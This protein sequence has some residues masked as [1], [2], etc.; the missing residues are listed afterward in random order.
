[1]L[2]ET[3][4]KGHNDVL[5][6]LSALLAFRL[7][8]RGGLVAGVAGGLV[9]ATGLAVLP[10]LALSLMRRR[11]WLSLGVTVVLGSVVAVAA[12]APFWR[13]PETLLPILAQTSRV[14][15]SPGSLLVAAGADA[16]AARVLL[17]VVWAAICGVVLWRV[18]DPVASACLVLLATLLLLTTAF[19]AHY[20]VPVIALAAVSNSARLQRLSTALSIGAMAAYAVELLNLAFGPAF[21]G[22]ASFQIVGSLVLL[23]PAALVLVAG[24]RQRERVIKR[25]A[26]A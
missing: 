2:F 20:L 9:K 1:V 23:L 22:S 25:R 11:A 26:P 19:F 24:P 12:Y 6:A 5:L 8:S 16:G 3:L 18:G 13:G 10:S 17:A 14:V 4:A 7:S 21:I 15:W